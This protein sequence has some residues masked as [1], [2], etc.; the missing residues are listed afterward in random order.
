MFRRIVQPGHVALVVDLIVRFLGHF[1]RNHAANLIFGVLYCAFSYLYTSTFATVR[2]LTHT[3]LYRHLK[4][5]LQTYLP[6]LK[7]EQISRLLVIYFS[8]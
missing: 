1:I 5:R 7:C 2:A 6:D 3:V 4:S 8:Y